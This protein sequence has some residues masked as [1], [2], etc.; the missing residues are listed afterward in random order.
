MIIHVEYPDTFSSLNSLAEYIDNMN[1]YVEELEQEVRD[2]EEWLE[3]YRDKHG[4][5]NENEE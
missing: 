2:L 5:L 1:K 3:K 4:E